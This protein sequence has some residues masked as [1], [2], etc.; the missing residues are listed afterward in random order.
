MTRNTERFLPAEC[1]LD[2]ELE[3]TVVV[4]K[5]LGGGGW[6]SKL[7]GADSKGTCEEAVGLNWKH[8]ELF[9]TPIAALLPPHFYPTFRIGRTISTTLLL[10]SRI[11]SG[12]ARV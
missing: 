3:S 2:F 8:L 5:R 1:A 7:P 4:N 12:T 11:A 6:E 10:A 9:G